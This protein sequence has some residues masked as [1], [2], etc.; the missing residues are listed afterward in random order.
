MTAI[1]AK[2]TL[3][4]YAEPSNVPILLRFFKTGPGQYGYGD[5]FIGVKVPNS[6]RVARE[7]RGLPHAEVLKLLKSP[8]HEDRFLGLV[9]WTFQYPKA[10]LAQKKRIYTAYLAATRKG[11]INNWDLVDVSTPLVVGP[12]LLDHVADPLK[13]LRLW[14]KSSNLWIRRVAMLST[15][16]WIRRGKTEPVWVIAAD[17]LKDEQD[18]IHKASGWMLREAGKKDLLGLRRFLKAHAA[19]MPRTMLRYSIEKMS[20]A[21][22]KKWMNQKGSP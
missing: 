4:K 14:A 3:R 7:F 16:A 18:L 1:E 21:E 9:I 2:A 11:Q 12:Y 17:L 5:Q 8:I 19:V 15:F 10:D 20:A 6:R 22:R 13:S